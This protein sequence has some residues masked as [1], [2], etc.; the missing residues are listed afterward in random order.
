M[1]NNKIIQIDLPM[2]IYLLEGMK[3]LK[4]TKDSNIYFYSLA[5]TFGAVLTCP[6]E[7]IKTRYQSSQNEFFQ[8][9][10]QHNTTSYSSTRPS[11]MGSLR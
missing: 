6:L 2:Y 5:G 1:S 4:V 10:N 9:K 8:E 3:S 7:V 11:I